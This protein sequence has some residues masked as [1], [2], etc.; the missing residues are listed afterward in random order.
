M[1]YLRLSLMAAPADKRAQ[2]LKKWSDVVQKEG[3]ARGVADVFRTCAWVPRKSSKALPE[4][5]PK[6]P[7][8]E[9]AAPVKRVTKR[10]AAKNK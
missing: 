7:A 4:R 6:D 10:M 1:Y 8:S 2:I 3:A 9:E 5:A